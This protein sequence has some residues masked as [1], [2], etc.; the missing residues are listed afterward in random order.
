MPLSG[1]VAFAVEHLFHRPSAFRRA[2]KALADLGVSRALMNAELRRAGLAS[3]HVLR[4][5]ARV[6]HAY[7]L[8]GAFGAGLKE[9]VRR[10]GAGSVDSLSRE[11]K[12]VTT[13]PP[14]QMCGR[15]TPENIIRLSLDAACLETADVR[16][17]GEKPHG[18]SAHAAA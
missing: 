17:R 5:I 3:F 10:V 4:R 8:I 6:A 16:H 13:L 12:L 9:V 15:L 18:E 11:A 7:Q 1:M 14:A 2:G